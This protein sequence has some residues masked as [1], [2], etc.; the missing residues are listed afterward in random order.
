MPRMHRRRPALHR[1]RLAQSGHGLL[2]QGRHGAILVRRET[3]QYRLACVHEQCISP[4]VE[5]RARE[6]HTEV[7][8]STPG[9]PLPDEERHCPVPARVTG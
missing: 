3:T 8:L 9:A 4:G 5:Q 1:Q 2:A 7:E 6:L